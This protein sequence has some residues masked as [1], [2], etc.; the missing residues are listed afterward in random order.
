MTDDIEAERD[1]ATKLKDKAVESAN[2]NREALKQTQVLLCPDFGN[3]LEE[4]TCFV[5]GPFAN[6]VPKNRRAE[7]A[8]AE[9][10][11]IRRKTIEECIDRILR[12]QRATADPEV[13]RG[14]EL[15]MS[16]IRALAQTDEGNG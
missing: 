6:A 1:L 9:R 7:K 11:A 3:C 15:A 13:R 12:E 2:L 16:V 10:N 14:L 4:C 8:E 5:D